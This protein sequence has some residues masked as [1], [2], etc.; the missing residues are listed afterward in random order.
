[1]TGKIGLAATDMKL[2]HDSPSIAQ[3]DELTI[4]RIAA[5]SGEGRSAHAATTWDR[6]RP[7]A[8]AIC[9]RIC[10]CALKSEFGF[11]L[12]CGACEFS[13]KGSIPFTR[14]IY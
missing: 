5:L 11:A 4:A 8:S 14:S 7:N 6:S 3:V 12:F 13:A 2:R 9:A 1:M 10:V